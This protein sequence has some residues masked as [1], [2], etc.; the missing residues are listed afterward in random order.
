MRLCASI[1]G[2]SLTDSSDSGDESTSVSMRPRV[3][4]VPKVVLKQDKGGYPILPTLREMNR[5]GLSYKKKVIS[6]FMSEVLSSCCRPLLP[7][8]SLNRF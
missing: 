5:Y 4:D 3:R 1:L 8:Q 2:G 6:E 7:I